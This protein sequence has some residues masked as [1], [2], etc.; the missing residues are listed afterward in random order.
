M[1]DYGTTLDLLDAFSPLFPSISGPMVVV[2]AVYRRWTT[3]PTSYAGKVVY[4]SKCRNIKDL[5]ASRMNAGSLASWELDLP[6]VACYDERV[7]RCV[8]TLV[9]SKALRTLTLEA[10]ITVGTEDFRMVIPFDTFE[11]EIT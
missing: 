7:R 4:K 8:V 9:G 2:Q 3:D 10:S 1:P 5:L 11:P 6:R